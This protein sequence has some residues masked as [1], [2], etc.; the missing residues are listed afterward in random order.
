MKPTEEKKL[1]FEEMSGKPPAAGPPATAATAAGPPA[2][3]AAAEPEKLPRRLV[4]LLGSEDP[5]TKAVFLFKQKSLANFL[6][7]LQISMEELGIP[8][9][10]AAFSKDSLKRLVS[11]L[12]QPVLQIDIRS[13]GEPNVMGLGLLRKQKINVP[14]IF[15]L[16]SEGPALLSK[17]ENYYQAVPPEDMPE[18]LFEL[19]EDRTLFP[20]IDPQTFLAAME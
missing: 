18:G 15:I 8:R 14:Y 7:P 3:A 19:F 10:S 11:F 9:D 1:F 12:R 4:A 6:P 5:K 13:D 17:K 2:T 16:T 20:W